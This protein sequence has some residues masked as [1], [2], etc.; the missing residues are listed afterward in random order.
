MSCQEKSCDEQ[1]DNEQFE[2]IEYSSGCL[3]GDLAELVYQLKWGIRDEIMLNLNGYTQLFC[4]KKLGTS[5]KANLLQV[6]TELYQQLINLPAKSD[7]ETSEE[8]RPS[9]VSLELSLS[10]KCEIVN[11]LIANQSLTKNHV[12]TSEKARLQR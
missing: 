1:S 5:A 6:N 11:A 3:S 2:K 10:D 8:P 7:E 4:G 12:T 9:E